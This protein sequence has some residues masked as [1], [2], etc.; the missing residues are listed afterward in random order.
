MVKSSSVAIHSILQVDWLHFVES[1]LFWSSIHV[2][3]MAFR[4]AVESVENGEALPVSTLFVSNKLVVLQPR[5]GIVPHVSLFNYYS[6]R[7]VQ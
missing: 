4:E 7:Q 1:V 5:I 3:C 6:S 2:Q